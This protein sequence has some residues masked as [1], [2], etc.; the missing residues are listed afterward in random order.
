MVL[1]FVT[2]ARMKKFEI[3]Q[4]NTIIELN[5]LKQRVRDLEDIVFAA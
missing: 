2:K 3:Q 1:R 5:L 4:R